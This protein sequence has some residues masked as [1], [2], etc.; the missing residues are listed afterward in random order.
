MSN[1]YSM[2][3]RHDSKKSLQ[4]QRKEWFEF[5]ESLC[6]AFD[7]DFE[8]L[9]CDIGNTEIA[10]TEPGEIDFLLNDDEANYNW[11]KGLRKR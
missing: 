10:N 9:L 4:Q 5:L 2:I 11:S 6:L 8:Q 1:N 3:L 7:Q